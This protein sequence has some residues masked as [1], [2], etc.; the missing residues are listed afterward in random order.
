MSTVFTLDASQ[1]NTQA[2]G[3]RLELASDALL[4]ALQV[5]APAIPSRST[6]PILECV[7]LESDG[8]GLRLSA[9][10]LE[11]FVERSLPLSAPP[12]RVAVPARRLLDTL[13]A[14][15]T[16]PIVLEV[17]SG[18]L[19]LTTA[20]GRYRMATLPAEEFP[21]RPN[22]EEGTELASSA[23]E[24][25]QAIEQVL[26]AASTDDLRPALNG[27]LL[28]VRPEE[29]RLVATDGH[30][31]VRLRS[32][33]LFQGSVQESR[34]AILPAR[35]VGML[36]KMLGRDAAETCRIRLGANQAAF[37][38]GGVL[39][40]T[41]LIGEAY[42]NY[43]AVIPTSWERRL[44]IDR[45]AFLKALKRVALYASTQ[46]HQVRLHLKPGE[47][48]LEA[49]DLDRANSAQETVIAELEGEPLEIGFNAKYLTEAL[50]HLDAAEVLLECTRPNRAAVLK[51][52]RSENAEDVLMLIMP[53][54]LNPY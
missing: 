19:Q 16:E 43:E 29:V 37:S 27:V 5:L 15:D 18:S 39:F 35:V 45:E 2:A 53:V 24:L 33:H 9:T 44:R 49:E 21:S 22:L 30:R 14:L 11:I 8:H 42:P 48:L 31:L 28:E 20:H 36:S 40:V 17:A 46:V 10:D 7:L 13:R 23:E 51:P 41:R 32:A 6:M 34:N 25:R 3:V 1:E 47:L 50:S 4:T 38:W 52:A 54:M 12:F 26:F